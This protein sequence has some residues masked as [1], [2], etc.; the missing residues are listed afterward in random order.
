MD[1][2]ILSKLGFAIRTANEALDQ[3]SF[4]EVT[5]AIYNFW[6]YDLCDVYLVSASKEFDFCRFYLGYWY[7]ALQ[8]V[9][10]FKSY[11]SQYCLGVSISG[12]RP[13]LFGAQFPFQTCQNC[14]IFV[15]CQN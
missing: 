7:L 1:R 8:L 12:S 13:V 14:Q 10:Y 9:Q 3:Y 4:Q 11:R 15:D 2:W 5:T 6:L